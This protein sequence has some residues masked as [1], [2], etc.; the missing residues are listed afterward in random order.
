VI[1]QRLLFPSQATPRLRPRVVNSNIHEIDRPLANSE[2][3]AGLGVIGEECLAEATRVRLS[4][5]KISALL[6]DESKELGVA[7]L[8]VVAAVAIMHKSNNT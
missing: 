8:A 2:E 5:G 1:P 3:V 7:R 6:R 4:G